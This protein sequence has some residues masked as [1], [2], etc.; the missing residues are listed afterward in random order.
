MDCPFCIHGEKLLPDKKHQISE[1]LIVTLDKKNHFHIH[2]P[3]KKTDLIMQMLVAI[4]R[5]SGIV[6]ESES[7]DE[8]EEK[9]IE[10]IETIIE[11]DSRDGE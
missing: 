4:S 10:I 8:S 5:E 3:T 9:D 1:H 6:I 11:G 2:G 7:K